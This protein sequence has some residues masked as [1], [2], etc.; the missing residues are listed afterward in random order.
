MKVRTLKWPQP[1]FD[2][3][4][5]ENAN[6]LIMEKLTDEAY[7]KYWDIVNE[8]FDVVWQ[9]FRVYPMMIANDVMVI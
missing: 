6:R 5:V 1:D 4:L 9:L 3:D 8:K 7:S 2:Q